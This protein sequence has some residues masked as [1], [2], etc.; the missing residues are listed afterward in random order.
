MAN[1]H[2]EKAAL[3]SSL[4]FSIGIMR[5]SYIYWNLKFNL[6]F[7]NYVFAILVTKLFFSK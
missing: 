5:L 1:D 7:N 4:K 2:I 3:S 6:M